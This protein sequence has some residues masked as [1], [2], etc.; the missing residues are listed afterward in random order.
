[1]GLAPA[2]LEPPIPPPPAKLSSPPPDPSL[3]HAARAAVHSIKERAVLIVPPSIV[4]SPTRVS[5]RPLRSV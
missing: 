4:V 3:L 1:M 5:A 2:P